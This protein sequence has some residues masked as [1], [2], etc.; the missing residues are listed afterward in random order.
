MM[1]LIRF[2]S[3]SILL[4]FLAASALVD[5]NFG[6]VEIDWNAQP[7]PTLTLKAMAENG[8]TGFSH[9]ISLGDLQ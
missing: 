4:S 1:K 8:Q 7:A 5:L 2:L 9:R 3:S 6:L